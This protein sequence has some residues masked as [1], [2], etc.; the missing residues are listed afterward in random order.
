MS[1]LADLQAVKCLG[2]MRNLPGRC[3]EL[4]GDM[5]GR[6]ALDLPDGKRLVFKPAEPCP[7]KADGGLDWKAVD[8]V[9]I[10]EIVNYHR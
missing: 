10:L 1:R 3:H 9:E 6:L 5:A 7:V 2:D 8:A 4:S